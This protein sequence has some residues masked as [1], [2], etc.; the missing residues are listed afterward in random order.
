METKLCLQCNKE[1]SIDDFGVCRSRADGR[2]Y[3]CKKCNVANASVSRARQAGSGLTTRGEAQAANLKTS[4]RAIERN[5]VNREWEQEV[6]RR[7]RISESYEHTEPLSF[8]RLGF[9]LG[10]AGN[11]QSGWASK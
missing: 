3:Y 11:K 7:I 9:E 4:E 6:A 5:R 8:S 10:R 2:N 1:L